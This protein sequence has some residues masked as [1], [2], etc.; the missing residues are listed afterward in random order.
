M[1]IG[2][3][4]LGRVTHTDEALVVGSSV[5]EADMA[6]VKMERCSSLAIDHIQT[7][8]F[9]WEVE[10]GTVQSKTHTLSISILNKEELLQQWK[11]SVIFMYL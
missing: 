10:Q 7:E 9:S 3:T 5:F 4:M 2:V 11:E 1:F 6:V 8:V